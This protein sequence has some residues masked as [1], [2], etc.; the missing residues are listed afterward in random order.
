MQKA[1]KQIEVNR[2]EGIIGHFEDFLKSNFRLFCPACAG[3]VH[4]RGRDQTECIKCGRVYIIH[5][6]GKLFKRFYKNGR[7]KIRQIY[8]KQRSFSKKLK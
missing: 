2:P 4:L 8:R 5:G 3:I 7:K 1:K 6:A